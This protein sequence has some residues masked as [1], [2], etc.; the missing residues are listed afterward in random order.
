MASSRLPPSHASFLQ[1]NPNTVRSD[2]GVDLAACS[3]PVLV[4][5][6]IV[7]ALTQL[8]GWGTVGLVAIVGRQMADELGMSVAAIFAG[9]S[10]LY[11]VMGV[12]S[13]FLAKTF[14][15]LG[16]R[17]VMICGTAVAI[18]GF[19]ALAFAHGLVTYVIA[20]VILGMGGSATLTTPAFVLLNEVVGRNARSA[21]GALMLA[22]GLSSSLFW[23]I[24][25]LLSHTVD[26]RSI[27]LI[28][29][30]SLALLSLPLLIFGL[31]RRAHCPPEAETAEL[32]PP[33]AAEAG[34]TFWLV[35]GAIALNAFVTFGFSAILIELL[36]AE[37]LRPAEAVAFGSALGII[38]VSARGIDF[39]GGGRWDGITTGL[40]A[41]IALPVAMTVLIVG[42]GAYWSVAAFI[43][44]YGLGSG[45]LA[46]ARATI[47]LVFYDKSAFARATS[48]IALPLNVISALSPPGLAAL[49]THLGCDAVLGLAMLCSCGALL[50]LSVLG[51]RR[52]NRQ[53]G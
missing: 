35:V 53:P 21:I 46:V 2:G 38:Q 3:R 48:H 22:T 37:G 7:L 10:I 18:L 5:T 32:A 47:P 33:L 36:K 26:W 23:P 28:Y 40:F 27:C 13:P 41:G 49:L 30:T 31:P 14:A 12:C 34:G 43:L 44:L 15:R 51:R 25:S 9:N 52:P 4:R 19:A 45:A 16:A 1:G 6:L 24:A 20:W 42:G 29:A 50:I 39:L 11:L 8:I 17:L